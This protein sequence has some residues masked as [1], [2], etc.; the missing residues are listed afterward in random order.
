MLLYWDAGFLVKMLT[1]EQ[2]NLIVIT[3]CMVMITATIIFAY[4]FSSTAP[5]VRRHQIYMNPV[6]ADRMLQ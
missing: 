3:I 5:Q 1:K 4:A 2:S 6:N